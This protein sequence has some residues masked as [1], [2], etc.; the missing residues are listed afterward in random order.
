MPLYIRP[1]SEIE[2]RINRK[3]N[4]SLAAASFMDGSDANNDSNKNSNIGNWDGG[5]G[6]DEGNSRE[7]DTNH[8]EPK[9]S[10]AARQRAEVELQKK[11]KISLMKL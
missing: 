11:R 9:T 7:A 10:K 5:D 1:P 6:F 8:Q 3:R 2:R 4:V